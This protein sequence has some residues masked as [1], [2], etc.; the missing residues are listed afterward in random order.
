MNTSRAGSKS[1]YLILLVCLTTSLALWDLHN[2][3]ALNVA[4]TAAVTLAPADADEDQDEDN[5]ETESFGPQEEQHGEAIQ[6][7]ANSEKQKPDDEDHEGEYQIAIPDDA[8]WKETI[9]ERFYPPEV[10]V[11][12]GSDVTWTNEDDL[13]HTITS[14]KKAGYGMYEFKQDGAFN[15][16]NLDEGDSFTFHFTEPGRYE[17]FCV[18]H[19]WMNGAVLVQ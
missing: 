9:S 16:G 4:A 3:Q 18:P 5:A 8:A 15:S 19:P 17:Y 14:G 13:T 6:P 7:A 11:P 1:V 10:I 12:S 2:F